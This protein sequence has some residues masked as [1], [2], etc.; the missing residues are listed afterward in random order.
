M[1]GRTKLR[2]Y[3]IWLA[4][5][6]A[7][8]ILLWVI[9]GLIMVAKPIEEVRGEGLL[10]DPKP[11]ELAGPP[12]PPLVDG[13]PLSDLSIEQRAAGPRWVVK[14]ADGK[15]R[16]A[17][18]TT[19]LLLPE[20]S[21]SDARRE[22][23]ARYTGKAAI[24][25][26]VRTN[27]DDPPIDLRRPLATWQVTMD[28]GARFYVDMAS[29]QIVATRTGWWRFYD[30]MWGLHIMD[31]VGREDAHNPFVIGFGILALAMSLLGTILLPKALKKKRKN[32]A[33]DS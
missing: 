13:V 6:V 28:D 30:F 5:I 22:V 18:P 9:S 8:P 11:I 3:H 15:R 19:G 20:L 10:R 23:E 27:A 16:L 25:S 31:P 1:S 12:I 7:I 24:K 33:I 14:L 32:A 4:W 17:D 2:R 29:G 26:V 21:A